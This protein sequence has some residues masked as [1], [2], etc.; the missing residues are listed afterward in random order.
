[1]A[2]LARIVV[3][4]LPHHVTGRADGITVLALV[5]EGYPDFAAFIAGRTR[6]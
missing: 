5:L 1:M 6:R 4:G 2:R 3:P